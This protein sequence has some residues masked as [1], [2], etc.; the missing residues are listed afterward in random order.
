MK[1]LHSTK[2]I[3][4]KRAGL[5][6]TVETTETARNHNRHLTSGLL[7]APG[8]SAKTQTNHKKTTGRGSRFHMP[9]SPIPEDYSLSLSFGATLNLHSTES[10]EKLFLKLY[11][12]RP[13]LHI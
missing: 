10:N 7:L 6:R 2:N 1:E 3:A 5:L 4:S 8:V 9:T 12:T 11:N 13:W